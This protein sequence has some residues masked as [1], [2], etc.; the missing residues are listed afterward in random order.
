MNNIKSR[1]LNSSRTFVVFALLV[2]MPAM[3][4]SFDCVKAQSRVEKLVCETPKISDLDSKLGQVYDE[5]LRKADPEQRKQLITEQKHWLQFTRNPC[6][7]ETCLKHA[8]W[9]RQ[10]ALEAWFEP[11]APLY[12]HESDKAEAIK[13]ILN[14]APLYHSAGTIRDINQFC[15][16]MFNDLKQMKGIRFVDPIVQ[17]RSYE[18][19]ALDRWKKNCRTKTPFHASI[20]CNRPETLAIDPELEVCYVDYGLPPFKLFE[21]PPSKTSKEKRYVFYSDTFYGPMNLR[22]SLSKYRSEEPSIRGSSHFVGINPAS[23]SFTKRTSAAAGP[24]DRNT[25]NYNSIIEYQG[26]YYFLSVTKSSG[27]DWISI[28]A[29]D[30]SKI[31]CRWT[32]V[33]R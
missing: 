16:R 26:S 27:R 13:K 9:S 6:D 1:F 21:L 31:T 3:G 10:A 5:A 8:Y 24:Q 15:V 23:C 12:K 19:P 18:D 32:P 28:D 7:T 14:T 22:P 17:T 25:T 20:W 11:R 30:E 29:A 33:N 2:A 4:A